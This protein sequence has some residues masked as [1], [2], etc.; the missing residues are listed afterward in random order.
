MRRFLAVLQ[1]RM[2]Q[3][4]P[5]S[6]WPTFLFC[7]FIFLFLPFF[8]F[9]PIAYDKVGFVT[10]AAVAA[11]FGC[12]CCWP[13]ERPAANQICVSYP[14]PHTPAPPPLWLLNM[15]AQNVA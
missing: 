15:R 13:I 5:Q 4:E 14:P 7:T 2:L 3:F 10:A 12:A 8:S 1:N 11:A 9:W 6:N